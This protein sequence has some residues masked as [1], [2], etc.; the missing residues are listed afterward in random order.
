MLVKSSSLGHKLNKGIEMATLEDYAETAWVNGTAPAINSTNLLNI[1]GGI[2]RVTEAVQV[3]QD[4]N[5]SYVLP[6]ASS[7]TLGGVKIEVVNNGDGT[8]TGKIWV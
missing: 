8:F 5:S 6:P 7:A 4:N 1:E 3:L 2:D